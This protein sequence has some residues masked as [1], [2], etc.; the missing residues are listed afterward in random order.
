MKVELIPVQE[1][2][3]EEVAGMARIIWNDHYPEIVG[4]AQVDYMLDKIY[5]HES[6]LSQVRAEG[7]KF[8]FVSVDGKTEGFISVKYDAAE[9]ELFLNKFYL[10]SQ[11][12][13]SGIGTAAFQ[14]L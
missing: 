13:K 9:N 5:S 7:H 6:M 12:Q 8:Y 14:T 3:L 1:S 4:Q 11:K 2:Q 10:Y